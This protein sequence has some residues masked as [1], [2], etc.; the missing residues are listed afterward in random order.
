MFVGMN[1]WMNECLMNLTAV[2]A[3]LPF[4][5]MDKQT[6]WNLSRLWWE[7]WRTAGFLAHR[8][9]HFL[10]FFGRTLGLGFHAVVCR[11]HWETANW[12]F[13]IY[14]TKQTQTLI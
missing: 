4:H 9:T 5:F 13:V 10:L 14:Q 2:A 7:G 12:G 3:H 11:M 8:I 1:E 6:C